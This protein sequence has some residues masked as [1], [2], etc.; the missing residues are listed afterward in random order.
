MSG[1]K[2]TGDDQGVQQIVEEHGELE[3]LFGR[4]RACED[5]ALAGVSEELHR[6]LTSHFEHEERAGG[7]LDYLYRYAERHRDLVVQLRREHRSLL[8]D[9]TD[10]CSKMKDGDLDDGR[11]RLLELMRQ[12]EDHES[13]ERRVLES[14]LAAASQAS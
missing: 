14:A 10:I 8:Q 9:A 1:G 12:L 5:T 2:A 6:F 3:R 13:I 11:T 4:I 7:F